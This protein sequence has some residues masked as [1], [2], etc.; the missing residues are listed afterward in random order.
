MRPAVTNGG[1]LL[2]ALSTDGTLIARAVINQ[3]VLIELIT[4]KRIPQ[5]TLI[6]V[7]CPLF[8]SNYKVPTAWVCS[9]SSRRDC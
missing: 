8:S 2:E 5:M 1:S 3:E 9:S 7:H 4:L 6:S